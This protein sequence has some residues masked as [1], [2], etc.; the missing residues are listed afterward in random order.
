MRQPHK[1]ESYQ[2]PAYIH[3]ILKQNV[4]F[5]HQWT[6]LRDC[7]LS[8]FCLPAGRCHYDSSNIPIN[9]LHEAFTCVFVT[10]RKL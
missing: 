2:S 1:H 3:L 10:F 9:F 4:S 6:Y 7:V 5:M 8:S